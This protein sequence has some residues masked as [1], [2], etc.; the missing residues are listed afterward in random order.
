MQIDYAACFKP[1]AFRPLSSD[2]ISLHA[3]VAAFLKSC[4]SPPRESL[5]VSLPVI[6]PS[7]SYFLS[8][9]SNA[10][11]PSQG[12]WSKLKPGGGKNIKESDIRQ[13][14]QQQMALSRQRLL[15]LVYGDMETV[16]MVCTVQV[17]FSIAAWLMRCITS[18]QTR[19]WYSP[20]HYISVS[21]FQCVIVFG[22][23]NLMPWPGTGQSP[24]QMHFS[25]FGFRST[26]ST[27]RLP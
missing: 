19:L 3:V 22:P 21:I 13:H 2:L 16:R 25:A 8:R 11:L 17:I 18:S 24:R 12:F 5:F 14:Q 23:R 26:M 9:G 1:C 15:T 20:I 6:S 7:I 10:S 4:S 27:F